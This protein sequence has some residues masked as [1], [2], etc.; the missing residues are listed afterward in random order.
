MSACAANQQD[1]VI[2]LI[3]E[4]PRCVNWKNKAGMTAMMHAAKMGNDAVVHI[5]LDVGEADINSVDN[6]GCAALHVSF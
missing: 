1:V 6:G 4:F 2:Y 5:L 3:Q